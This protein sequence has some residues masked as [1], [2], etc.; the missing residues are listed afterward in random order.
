MKILK[1]SDKTLERY[2]KIYRVSKWTTVYQSPEWLNVLKVLSGEL[3]F[4]EVNERTFIPLLCRGR[5]FFRRCFSL[6]FD[7]YGGVVSTEDIRVSFDDIVKTLRA[8]FIRIVD[9]YGKM[10]TSSFLME[11]FSSHFLDLTGGYERVFKSYSSGQRKAVRQSLRRGLTIRKMKEIS[12]LPLFY[13][14]YSETVKKYGKEPLPFDFLKFLFEIMVPKD[15][16]R[17]YLAWYGDLAVGGNL[18]LRDKGSA[19][20]WLIGYREEYLFL[21]TTNA[22]ID[23]AIFDEIESGTEIFNLGTTPFEKRG[24][25][26]FKEGFGAKRYEFRVFSK[27]GFSYKIMKKISEK[28][29]SKR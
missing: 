17:F 6:P 2:S 23:R 4:I 24:V 12:E 7:T 27:I 5:S 18:I 15:M 13:H 28:L 29:F 20:D 1:E 22:L 26:N 25:I 3:L 16:A 19:F 21:R 11:S 10:E 8:P 14:L 9:F